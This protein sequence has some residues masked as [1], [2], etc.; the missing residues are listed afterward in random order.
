MIP[1]LRR[2]G[3]LRASILV[4]W[5]MAPALLAGQTEPIKWTVDHDVTPADKQE[6]LELAARLG[7]KDPQA[8]SAD[9]I[10]MPLGCLA[11]RVESRVSVAGNRRTWTETYVARTDSYRYCHNTPPSASVGHWQVAAP[12]VLP[13]EVWRIQDGDW[14]VDA[15]L[16]AGVTYEM[17]TKIILAF[18]TKTFVDRRKGPQDA[19]IGDQTIGKELL[20]SHTVSVYRSQSH[21]ENEYEIGTGRIGGLSLLVTVTGDHVELISMS[22]WIA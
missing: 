12:G 2:H 18:K 14:Y 13:R 10:L 15:R 4:V 1:H 20:V 19:T 17:A 3:T 16:G 6:I 21:V 9:I 5:I 8:V 22:R 11:L 7:I